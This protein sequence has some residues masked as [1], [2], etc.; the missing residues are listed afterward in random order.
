MKKSKKPSIL[1]LFF[2]LLFFACGL[3][4][5][6][7]KVSNQDLLIYGKQFNIE[8]EKR[9]IPIIPDS[10]DS[11]SSSGRTI[12]QNP[13]WDKTTR[14]YG[15]GGEPLIIHYQKVVIIQNEYTIEETDI[16]LGD[17]L[18]IVADNL[19]LEKIEI[20]C[21][22]NPNNTSE[23]KCSTKINT[24]DVVYSGDDI[25]KAIQILSEWNISYP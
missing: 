10:W 17:A 15:D 23:K 13:V 24:K 6:I 8:R 16:Y 18:E 12:W 25:D 22:Y 9:D 11:F 7:N 19:V 2:G 14:T 21:T 4:L 5:L 20:T 1:N 3:V